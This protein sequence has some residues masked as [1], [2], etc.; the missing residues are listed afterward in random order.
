MKPAA[1]DYDRPT[2]LAAATTQIAQ[3][4]GMVKAMAGGQ[5]LGAMLNLRLAQ[6]QGVVDLRSIQELSNATETAEAVTLGA[7]VTHA[8]IEDRRVPDATRGLMPKVAADIAYR[9]IRNRGTIGGSLVHADPAADWVSTL[10]LLNATAI[11]GGPNGRREIRMEEF[12]LGA[13]E[14]ALGM[15]EILI[16]IRIEKFSA[17][18]RWGYWKFCRKT[19]EFAEASGGV[20]IDPARKICRAVIGATNGKPYIIHD[21]RG[22][23][24]Q[25]DAHRAMQAVEAAGMGEDAYERQMHFVALQRAAA[26]IHTT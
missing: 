18:A 21:A 25:F 13:F 2:D 8:R 10:S 7:C 16:A 9:A 11:I 3:G 24:D 1:F 17:N 23:A 26:A 15:D 22:I 14:T 19:G 20:L 12:L 6:P 5:S 4:D